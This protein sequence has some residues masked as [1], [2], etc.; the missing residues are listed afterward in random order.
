MNQAAK[1]R[2]EFKNQV[3]EHQGQ[4]LEGTSQL[5]MFSEIGLIQMTRYFEVS[6]EELEKL[7]LLSGDVLVIEGNGSADQIGSDALVSCEIEDCIHLTC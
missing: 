7:R 2:V 4:I 3:K 1:L 6:D 5:P